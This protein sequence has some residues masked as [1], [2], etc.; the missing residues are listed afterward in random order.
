MAALRKIRAHLA[1]GGLFWVDA[2]D[3]DRTRTIKIDHPFNFTEDTLRKLVERAGFR[4]LQ[5]SR[6]G[7]HVGFVCKAAA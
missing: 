5:T 1:D 2:L 6:D 4:I 3:Y 7:D